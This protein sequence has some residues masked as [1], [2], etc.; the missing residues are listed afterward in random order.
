MWIIIAAAA[1]VIIGTI[2]FF[3]SQSHPKL[4]FTDKR[5]LITGGSSGIGECMAYLFSNLGAY[6]TL[7]SNQPEDVKYIILLVGTR[8]E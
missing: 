4:D 7:A 8:Q 5:V 6:L 1:L 2:I 3:C